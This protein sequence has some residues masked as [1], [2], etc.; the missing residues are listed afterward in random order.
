MR[1]SNGVVS[2]SAL[3]AREVRRVTSIIRVAGDV[4]VSAGKALL[5]TEEGALGLVRSLPAL[6]RGRLDQFKVAARPVEQ[7]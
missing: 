5:N 7:G 6:S 1:S 4:A 3:S 2:G